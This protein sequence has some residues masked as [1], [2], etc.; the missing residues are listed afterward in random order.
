MD[1]IKDINQGDVLAF[2]ADDERY[3]AIICTSVFDEKSPQNFTFAIS[4]IDQ[5]DRP[6]IDKILKHNFFGIGNIKADYFRYSDNEIRIMWNEHPEIEPYHLGAYGLIIWRKDFMKFRDKFK[7]IGNI[8]IVNNLDKNGTGSVNA[9]DWVFLRD[10]FNK[11][12]KVVLPERGQK[13]FRVK[14]IVKD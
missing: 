9:S 13:Q 2:K 8:K 4:T 3:K 11:K 14:A 10:F 5:S 6:T 7:L 12:F 1:N